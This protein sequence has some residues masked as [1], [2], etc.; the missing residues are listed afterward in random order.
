MKMRTI[1]II[2]RKNDKGLEQAVSQI[3]INVGNQDTYDLAVEVLGPPIDRDEL[4]VS[5]IGLSYTQAQKDKIFLT[6]IGSKIPLYLV[7]AEPSKEVKH[8]AGTLVFPTRI[9][10]EKRTI[11]AG[12]FDNLLNAGQGTYKL[13]YDDL[14]RNGKE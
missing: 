14:V 3:M 6:V 7:V 13:S 4:V 9:N 12:N 10:E 5:M 11:L 1:V 2:R 8:L